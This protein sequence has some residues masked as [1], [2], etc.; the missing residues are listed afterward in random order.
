[1]TDKP[2]WTPG[3]MRAAR[4]L[5]IAIHALAA[6]SGPDGALHPANAEWL[7]RVCPEDAMIITRETGDAEMYEAL[8][9]IGKIARTEPMSVA[10][11]SIANIAETVLA[12]AR[13]ESDG[14]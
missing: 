5:R 3:A 9:M 14:H 7:D 1:M 10:D 13:G 2:K 8:E 6:T 4:S 12:K 11:A